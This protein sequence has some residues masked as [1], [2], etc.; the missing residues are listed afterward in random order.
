MAREIS[1]YTG[2]GVVY[3][4][5][6]SG[7]VFS[8]ATK[9]LPIGSNLDDL[10]KTGAG[11]HHRSLPIPSLPVVSPQLWLASGTAGVSVRQHRLQGL[12]ACG[13]WYLN[14]SQS[15]PQMKQ[16]PGCPGERYFLPSFPPM[17]LRSSEKFLM[18]PDVTSRLD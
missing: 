12:E 1:L 18:R 3:D 17:H 13:H 7:G 11:S 6:A 14:R 16:F 10:V 8:P 9:A 5:T 15:N 2:P 4:F